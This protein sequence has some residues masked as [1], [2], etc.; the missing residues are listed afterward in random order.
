M[1][2][3]LVL[4]VVL[5]LAPSD[6][7]HK[8]RRARSKQAAT[9]LVRGPTSANTPGRA[10]HQAAVALGPA[11]LLAVCRLTVCARLLVL[12]LLLMSTAVLWLLWG[13]LPALIVVVML[14]LVWGRASVLPA[15]LRLAVLLLGWW[16]AAVAVL[17]LAGMRGGAVVWLRGRLVSALLGRVGALMEGVSYYVTGWNGGAVAT[18][19][20]CCQGGHRKDRI[21]VSRTC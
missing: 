3:L 9:R 2:H 7:A 21:G 5:Q 20:V 19:M 15:V 1:V 8:R 6:A 12:L 16:P 14:L 11:G 10:A 4:G 13:V 18:E 17:L